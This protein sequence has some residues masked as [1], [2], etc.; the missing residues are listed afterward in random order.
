MR[1]AARARWAALSL[2]AA[3]SCSRANASVIAGG[4]RERGR[5]SLAA[6]GCG[7]CHDIDGVTGAHGRVGPPLDGVGTRSMLAGEIP[8]T[9]DNMVRWI[10]HP[11]SIEPN[12]AMPDLHVGPQVA[13][14]MVAYL[15]TL[16]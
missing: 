14:D 8:N 13:R 4:N 6:M 3:M 12:T 15:Y 2:L 7:S 11:D 10:Q 1:M 9:P 16:R 5:T